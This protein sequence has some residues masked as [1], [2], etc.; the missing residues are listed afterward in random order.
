MRSVVIAVCVCITAACVVSSEPSSTNKEVA[1]FQRFRS[2]TKALRLARE[3][4]EEHL[5]LATILE[6]RAL[7]VHGEVSQAE[8][9]EQEKELNV[10]LLELQ[11][12]GL[13]TGKLDIEPIFTLQN[14]LLTTRKLLT[15]K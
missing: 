1:L 9:L 5:I 7:Y 11:C 12:D 8:W 15:D 6:K 10:K 2:V 3:V 4:P 14:S 13:T